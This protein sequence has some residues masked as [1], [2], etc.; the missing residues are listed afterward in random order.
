MARFSLV[1]LVFCLGYGCTQA[2]L[3]SLAAERDLAAAASLFFPVYA[4]A[5]LLTRPLTGRLYD[6]RG[7]GFLF[8]PIFVLTMLS[9]CLMA[10]AES[11]A[12]LLCAAA[13][14]GMGFGNF[15]SVGQAVSLSLVTLSRVPQATT[16]FFVFFDLGIGIGPVL[17]GLLIPAYGYQGLYFAAA[18]AVLVSAVLYHF[19]HGRHRT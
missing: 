3:T 9:F 7:E 15:Q 18:A 1:A 6:A 12:A 16:T 11:G 13:L 2:F 10:V 19:L 14:L 17:L 4:A 8:P 5:T